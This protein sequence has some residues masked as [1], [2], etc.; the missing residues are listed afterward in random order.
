MIRI[1]ADEHIPFLK[2]SLEPYAEVIYLPGHHITRS[3]LSDADGLIT[4]TRT[5]C[6]A[7]L[8]QGTP[9]RFIASATSGFEHIDTAFCSAHHIA[10]Y[11]A[12][13]CNSSSVT[14]YVASAL[15][16]LSARNHAP[17]QGL[18]IGII[19]AGHIGTKVASLSEVLGL[20]VLLNDPPRS[21]KEGPSPFV[22]LSRVL[23]ESDII[24]L[25]VPLTM[26]GQDRT[27]HLI[28]NKACH[29]MK[30]TLWLLNTSRGQ[31][32]DNEALKEAL[33]AGILQDVV[34]D[35]W[36]NEPDID[37]KL[38]H[39]AGLATPHIAGY[40]VDG[41]A[42]ATAMCLEAVSRFFGLTV[43]PLSPDILPPPE[44]PVITIDCDGKEPYEILQEA[45]LSS[46]DIEEDD[47]HLRHSPSTF[48]AQRDHYPVRR[49][50][51]AFTVHLIHPVKNIVELLSRTGFPVS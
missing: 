6:D 8:L 27:F 41:K 13:G 7:G 14:Q 5:R 17:L 40:S 15:A 44:K 39:M 51:H 43:A 45:I 36:D 21:R 11:H 26:T 3:V 2:G 48:E 9:V 10:W 18:T 46:Y 1:V 22:S 34:L 38:M 20:R 19:G 35:V 30:K 28:N 37:Q 16:T 24:T 33:K 47:R 25:H 50:F 23:D 31:V 32:I 4:R 42:N 49:E 29:A 12:A